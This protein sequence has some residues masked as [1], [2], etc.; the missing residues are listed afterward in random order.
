MMICPQCG[1]T[2]VTERAKT[3]SGKKVAVCQRC[4]FHHLKSNFTEH[5]AYPTGDPGGIVGRKPMLD[6]E[7]ER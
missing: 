7:D 5:R 1:T 2:E 3:P 4:G 6:E